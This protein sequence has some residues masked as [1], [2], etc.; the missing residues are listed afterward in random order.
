M[1]RWCICWTKRS[2]VTT[3]WPG[4]QTITPAFFVFIRQLKIQHLASIVSLSVF[5]YIFYFQCLYGKEIQ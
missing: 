5:S 3:E 1:G 2:T 4:Q